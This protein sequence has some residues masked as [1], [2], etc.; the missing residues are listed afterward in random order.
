VKT[1]RNLIF[2]SRESL[3]KVNL[4]QEQPK[5]EN[6]GLKTKIIEWFVVFSTPKA[7]TLGLIDLVTNLNKNI[8][9]M[10]ICGYTI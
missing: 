7:S 4:S 5:G 9:N 2:N 8:L 10:K 6:L 1:K 3:R